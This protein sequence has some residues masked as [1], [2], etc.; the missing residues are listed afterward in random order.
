MDGRR[1]G[2]LI[3]AV[4]QE[5]GLRQVDVAARAGVSQRA[6]SRVELGELDELMFRTLDKVAGAVQVTLTLNANWRSG[7]GDRLLDQVHASI[8]AV[9]ASTLTAAGWTIIPEY[10]FNHFGDRGSVDILAFHAASGTLLIV[11]VKSRIHDLQ[12]LLARLA[13]KV[14]VVPGLVAH[15]RGWQVLHVA[16]LIVVP[17]TTANRSVVSRHRAIFDASFPA[18]GT[19]IRRWL[20]APSSA[21]AGVWFLDSHQAAGMRHLRVRKRRGRSDLR[22]PPPKQ[23]APES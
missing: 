8:V 9:V 12:D 18:R 19:Q 17:G 20:Q 3:R 11:E 14:R 1:V 6:V 23:P 21:L 5:L 4:R 15:E 10:T 22:T 16:R 7:A 2:R 13:T